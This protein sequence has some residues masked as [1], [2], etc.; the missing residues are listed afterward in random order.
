MEG[1]VGDYVYGCGSVVE[2]MAADVPGVIFIYQR[3]EDHSVSQLKRWQ[4]YYL[5]WKILQ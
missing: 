5:H 2:L 1:T 4:H 3:I